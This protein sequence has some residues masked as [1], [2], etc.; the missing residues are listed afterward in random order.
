[1]QYLVQFFFKTTI[2]TMPP[3]KGKKPKRIPHANETP[4]KHQQPGH[5]DVERAKNT[6]WS[7]SGSGGNKANS[8]SSIGQPK[9]YKAATSTVLQS[10]G[11]GSSTVSDR[12]TK[13]KV[14]AAVTSSTT[15]TTAAV[16]APRANPDLDFFSKPSR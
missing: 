2:A 6:M 7:S 14:P 8:C 9:K 5:G 1:M 4:L 13:K 12:G 11:I 3:K 10:I 16:G 15:G